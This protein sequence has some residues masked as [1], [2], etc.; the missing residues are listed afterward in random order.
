[1]ID[2]HECEVLRETEVKIT[3][4]KIDNQ[5]LWVFWDDKNGATAHGIKYCPY[6]GEKLVKGE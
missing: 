5:W 4:E 2:R 1:M 3:I 6:C